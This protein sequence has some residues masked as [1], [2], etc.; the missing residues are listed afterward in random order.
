MDKRIKTQYWLEFAN[1]IISLSISFAVSYFF[2]RYALH[3]LDDTETGIQWTVCIF[4][5]VV[6]FLISYFLFHKSVDIR[7]RNKV[8]EFVN[9]I[10]NDVLVFL[11]FIA[12]LAV[13]KN[14]IINRRFFIGCT[15]VV[16]LFL[17][18]ITR[19][20][21]KRW[22]TGGYSPVKSRISSYVGVLTTKD[23]A[24]EFIS[25]LKEDW[26]INITGVALL[27]NFVENG[28]FTYDK[29][30]EFGS[31][32]TNEKIRTKKKPTSGPCRDLHGT[33]V[34]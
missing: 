18:T 33:P 24:E 7:Q 26:S 3:K 29:N 9:T 12:L 11:I 28:R 21:L 23:R 30:F 6:A 34:G 13:V 32:Y 1:D 27:D 10:K 25:G 15:S 20:Y 8:G 19:Y 31:E 14:P 22:L 17:T 2:T 5:L 16:F 4:C